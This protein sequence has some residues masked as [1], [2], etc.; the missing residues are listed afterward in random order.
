MVTHI[1][2]IDIWKRGFK[3]LKFHIVQKGD[4]TSVNVSNGDRLVIEPK[5]K[6]TVNGQKIYDMEKE[7]DVEKLY[8]WY[9]VKNGARLV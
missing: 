2:D 7:P 1:D 4:T 5:W 6:V 8:R 3:T 9:L